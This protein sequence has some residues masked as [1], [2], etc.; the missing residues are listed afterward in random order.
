MSEGKT[1]AGANSLGNLA[2]KRRKIEV[3]GAWGQ[4]KNVL[5]EELGNV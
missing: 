2:E 5:E 1:A 3:R 4:G